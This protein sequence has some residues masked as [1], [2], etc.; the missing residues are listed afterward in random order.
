MSRLA[1]RSMLRIALDHARAATAG[2]LLL[3]PSGWG[4]RDRA[5]GS[6]SVP[7]RRD[8]SAAT[9]AT[10]PPSAAPEIFFRGRNLPEPER[11]EQET[12]NRDRYATVQQI[13]DLT[14]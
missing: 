7:S 4:A 8:A 13:F 10:P 11:P 12:L 3:M 1:E 9:G 14:T 2:P 6:R 5:A